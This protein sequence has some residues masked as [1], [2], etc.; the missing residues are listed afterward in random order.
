MNADDAYCIGCGCNDLN[1]CTGGCS[2]VRLD[3]NAHLGVCSECEHMVSDWD[4]GKRGFSPE[5]EANLLR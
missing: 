1:S 3:R 4:K 2:W 5:A